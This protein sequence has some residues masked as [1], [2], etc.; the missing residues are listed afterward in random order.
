MYSNVDVLNSQ[1]NKPM[2]ISNVIRIT[3]PHGLEQCICILHCNSNIC[4]L[5]FLTNKSQECGTLCLRERLWIILRI[6]KRSRHSK[7]TFIL[8]TSVSLERAE[9]AFLLCLTIAD[10][11]QKILGSHSSTWVQFR[12]M[13]TL[14]SADELF[15]LTG[16]KHTQ[17]INIPND[18]TITCLL[19]VKLWLRANID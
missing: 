4:H 18:E 15:E 9:M 7:S 17:L 8:E 16:T 10:P 12:H 11:C 19:Q 5:D 14:N 3:L 6:S 13:L 1:A 2:K